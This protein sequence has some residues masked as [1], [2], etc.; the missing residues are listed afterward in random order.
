[1]CIVARA[2]CGPSPLYLA[3][4]QMG[5]VRPSTLDSTSP[6]QNRTHHTPKK[7]WWPLD[8]IA[9]VAEAPVR[10]GAGANPFAIQSAHCTRRARRA[11]LAILPQKRTRWWGWTRARSR[12]RAC[13][14]LRRT[15]ARTRRHSMSASTATRT[16]RHVHVDVYT[17]VSMPR[18]AKTGRS[19]ARG[20]C[21]RVARTL[22]S[23]VQRRERPR[24]PAPPRPRRV[25]GL[26]N[27]PSTHVGPPIPYASPTTDTGR[28]RAVGKVRRTTGGTLRLDLPDSGVKPWRD[29]RSS[30]RSRSAVLL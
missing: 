15:T 18:R 23:S 24:V 9:R 3:A 7:K 25:R 26:Y 5:G 17:S 29:G 11:R 20:L 6:W 1:M 14:G 12:S 19:A 13:A 10:C 22:L 4:A 28:P 2:V 16:R 30:M 27:G 8:L 21:D